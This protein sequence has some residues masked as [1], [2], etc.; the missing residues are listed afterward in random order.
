MAKHELPVGG[1]ALLLAWQL[2]DKRVL[3]VGGGDVASGRISSV[4]IADALITL[5]SPRDGLHPL[6][7]YYIE[8]SDRITFHDRIFAGPADLEGIDMVLTAID[9]VEWSKRIW[10]MC[11]ER[12]IPVNV[13]DIPPNCDFYFGSQIRKGPLQIMISTNGN[14][15]K[16]ANIV[17]TRIEESL[18]ENVDQAIIK[19]GAL[20]AKLRQ[21]APGVGGNLGKRR[22][23]W[24]ISVCTKWNLDELAELDEATMETLLTEGWENNIVPK[25]RRTKRFSDGST[26]FSKVA[27]PTL[28]GFFVGIALSVAVLGDHGVYADFF[29]TISLIL[30]DKMSSLF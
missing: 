8:N 20:R 23:Q 2:K 28:V 19:V 5:I 14:G 22:M 26:F 29:T 17:K 4:L 13:A 18:P 7:K 24:M 11:K 6:T 12:K 3:I 9:D 30:R 21:R 25:P 10:T 27:F 16:L 1:G 15:P